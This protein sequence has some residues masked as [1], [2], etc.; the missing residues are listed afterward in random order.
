MA[1]TSKPRGELTGEQLAKTAASSVQAAFAPLT[2]D[3]PFNVTEHKVEESRDHDGDDVIRITVV[4]S[5][6]PTSISFPA[7]FAAE[8]KIRESF[9]NMGERRFVHIHHEFDDNQTFEKQ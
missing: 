7:I 5:L 2:A 8:S 9:W 3:A 1:A 6:S 4:H